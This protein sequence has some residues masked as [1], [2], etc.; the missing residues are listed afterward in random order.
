VL[1]DEA[2]ELAASVLSIAHGLVVVAN[3][4]L[5]DQSGEVVLITPANTLDSNGD[6]GG[7]DGVIADPD[8]GADEVGLLL[9]EEV[10]TGLGG[11]RGEAGEV[12]VGHLNE[13]V[14]GDAAGTDENHAVGCVVGLDVVGELGPGDVADVLAGSKDGAAQRLVLE[15]GGVQVVEDD[16]LEL[17][18]DLLRLSQDNV[19]LALDGRLLELRVL[20]D[21]GEDVDALWRI[22]IQ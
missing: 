14:V 15:S 19:A 5:G 9:G 1:V 18:L 21:I 10:G 6:V 4:G 16:L 3:D 12:L 2:A 13:L 8:I 11:L 7:R 22:L 20:E 17:L